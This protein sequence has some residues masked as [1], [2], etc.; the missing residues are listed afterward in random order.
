MGISMP[1]RSVTSSPDIL[2]VH[3][4]TLASVMGAD[5]QKLA[6]LMKNELLSPTTYSVIN[7]HE[8]ANQIEMTLAN[9]V[10]SREISPIGQLW[11]SELPRS[12]IIFQKRR[13]RH[14]FN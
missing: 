8:Q 7:Y 11:K 4:S 13:N 10:D 5:D 6:G 9:L 1:R 2:W 14:I 3:Q 12:F